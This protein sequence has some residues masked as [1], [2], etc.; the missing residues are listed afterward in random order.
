MKAL[1]TIALCGAREST[2]LAPEEALGMLAA[3][4][5]PHFF[6]SGAFQSDAFQNYSTRRF[7]GPQMS[8]NLD[9]SSGG[10]VA[11]HVIDVFNFLPLSALSF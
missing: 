9:I 1:S 5:W 2:D 11:A 10:H 7:L 6:I 8:V 3:S 4:P